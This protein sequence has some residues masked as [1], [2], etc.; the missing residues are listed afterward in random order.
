LK[1]VGTKI[2][3]RKKLSGMLGEG[4]RIAW[5]ALWFQDRNFKG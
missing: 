4:K 3:G 2:Y 5:N 1:A